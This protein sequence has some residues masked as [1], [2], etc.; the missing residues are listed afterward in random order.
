VAHSD[1]CGWKSISCSTDGQWSDLTPKPICA[2]T[3]FVQFWL[4]NFP[5]LR[6]KPSF[7]D[8]DDDNDN[9]D[10]DDDDD[11]DDERSEA[12]ATEPVQDEQ[13]TIPHQVSDL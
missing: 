11:D 13:L 2:W 10:D 3:T 1:V 12:S 9:D 5:K 6:A 8:D 7:D 4:K